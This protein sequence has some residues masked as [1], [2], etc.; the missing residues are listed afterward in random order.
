MTQARLSLGRLGE[1]LAARHLE[2]R[3]F[4][5]LGRNFRTPVGELDLVARDRGHLLFVEVKTRRGMAFGLPAEAVG[6]HKQRQIVRAAQWYLSSRSF[7]GLQ[8]RFD[9]IAV[10]V[11]AGE[12]AI[13]HI[14]NAFGI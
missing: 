9:V 12:P 11:G 5:I 2:Q 7:P 1:E 8:P 4:T 3:G 10:I 14:P 6:P 13:S